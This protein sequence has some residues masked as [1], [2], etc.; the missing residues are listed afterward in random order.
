MKFAVIGGS[1]FYD[2]GQK[3][4]EARRISTR[5]GD[6][7]IDVFQLENAEVVFLPR[8]GKGHTIAP[9]LINYRAN[10]S[11]LKQLGVE[12]ILASATVGSMNPRIIPG[13]LALPTQFIDFTSGRASTFFDEGL[14]KHVDMSEP[15]CP[16]LRQALLDC[17]LEQN[18]NLHPNV[19]Y[20]C[21]QGPRFETPAEIEMYRRIGGDVVGM[22]GVPEVVLAREAGICYAVVAL[23]TN[24]AAGMAGK[25]LSHT[26]WEE[27]RANFLLSATFS[28]H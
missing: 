2:A 28:F 17:A 22:T 12:C 7:D 15:Y 27:Q 11:A 3:A 26:E 19:T 16:N 20:I 13:K 18:L 21:T 14:V 5:Y 23:I 4:T 24:W 9:H 10:I 1:G 6:V 25:P 8:H